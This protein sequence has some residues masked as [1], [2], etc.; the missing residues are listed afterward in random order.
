MPINTKPVDGKAILKKRTDLELSASQLAELIGVT[1][2]KIYKWEGGTK[3]QT[4]K[5][6][7]RI[8][9]WLNGVNVPA[10]KK[11]T[12]QVIK[13]SNGTEDYKKKYYELLE[14]YTALLEKQNL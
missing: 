7:K 4:E 13:P 2:G 5:D 11:N 10:K 6:Y 9:D 12:V 8:T 14:K 1:N 3:P